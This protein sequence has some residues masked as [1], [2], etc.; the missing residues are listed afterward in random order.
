MPG[1]LSGDGVRWRVFSLEVDS[2]L[3]MWLPPQAKKTNEEQA[4]PALT[5]CETF[6]QG[7]SG[8]EVLLYID[9]ES[10]EGSLL[11]GYSRSPH[12]AVLAGTF[13]VWCATLQVRMWIGRVPSSLNPSEGCLGRM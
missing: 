1:W 8:C 5:W 12:L 3:S 13:W 2:S 4:L 6:G 7:I 10:A 9:S 11:S